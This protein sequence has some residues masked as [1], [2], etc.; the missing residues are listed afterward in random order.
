MVSLE[1]RKGFFGGALAG[2]LLAVLLVG[3]ASA[4]P[5]HNGEVQ[6]APSTNSLG[7][8]AQ[9]TTTL[10]TAATSAN[11]STPSAALIGGAGAVTT[12]VTSTIA[13]STTTT[14]ATATATSSACQGCQHS[15]YASAAQQRPSS[16]LVSLPGESLGS[17]LLALSPLLLGL[18]LA[19]AVYG[20]YS[21][22]Q[23][24]SE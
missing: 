19:G 23:R 11:Q 13:A 18:L 10:T 5:H 7:A 12:T 21:R 20:A 6:I 1:G 2:L 4:T 14:T 8:S 15:N 16:L 17:L 24:A 3:L 9:T 22:R